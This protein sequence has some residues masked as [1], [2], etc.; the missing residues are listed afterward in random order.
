MPR[1]FTIGRDKHCDVPVE[2]NSVSR[3][4]A[5][6]WMAEDGTLMMADLKSSN[7][8]RLI[9]N[10]NKLVL[11]ESAVLPDDQ[12]RFGVVTMGVGKLVETIESVYPHALTKRRGV[13]RIRCSCGVLKLPGEVCLGCGGPNG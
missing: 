8:T 7:G 13:T 5:E 2:D 1:R 3:K 11:A 12:V 4:H 10:G 9:R 6:I